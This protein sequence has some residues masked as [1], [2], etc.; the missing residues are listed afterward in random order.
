MVKR[1][2]GERTERE[3]LWVGW[4]RRE[5]R[6]WRVR[7]RMRRNW[8]MASRTRG[9]VQERGRRSLLWGPGASV[10]VASVPFE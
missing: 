5:E 7:W 2:K 1:G 3:R 6:E 4:E 9:S 8:A 10:V